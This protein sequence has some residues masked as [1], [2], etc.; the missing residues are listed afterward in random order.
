MKVT[1]IFD[2]LGAD[3]SEAIVA[4]FFSQAKRYKS[5]AS[6]KCSVESIT[7]PDFM[8]IIDDD[9]KQVAEI[10]FAS[11][12]FDM[13][14]KKTRSQRNIFMFMFL[15]LTFL[16]LVNTTSIVMHFLLCESFPE[17]DEGLD[18]FLVSDYSISC[19]SNRYNGNLF[20]CYVMI[21][22]Y[23]IGI[24]L[25]YFVLLFS[26]RNLN[27]E[28]ENCE[29]IDKNGCIKFLTSEYRQGFYYFEVFCTL[30]LII[31]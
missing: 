14:A 22:V 30:K 11:L 5:A 6:N 24:P 7:F 8:N 29:Q 1:L 26:H 2:E 23:P 27:A 31:L 16:V 10:N 9:R 12:A 17:S 21:I 28:R 3:N 15:F 20:F 18:S 13:N 19:L 4:K 25:V